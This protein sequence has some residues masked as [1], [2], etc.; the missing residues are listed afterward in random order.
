MSHDPNQDPHA[1]DSPNPSTTEPGTTESSTPAAQQSS[2]AESA[3]PQADA[4]QAE[5]SPTESP[6]DTAKQSRLIGSQR[7]QSVPQERPK[8]APVRPQKPE[9]A[10]SES[11]DEAEQAM[12]DSN[13]AEAEAAKSIN[14]PALTASNPDEHR[15][16]VGRDGKVEV[17]NI[18]ERMEDIEAELEAA[19]GGM[20]LDDVVSA[21]NVA[22]GA[23]RL[24]ADT[25]VNATIIRIH[26]EDV[27]FDLPGRNQGMAS[28][29]NFVALPNVG[30]KMEVVVRK[31]DPGE[32]L[33]DLGIPGASVS[34]SDWDD[35]EEG[36]VVDAVIDGVN[37]GGLEC[38]V[39]TARGFIPASQVATYHVEKLDEFLG[40]KMQCLVTEAKPEKR[41]L[42]LSARAVMEKTKEDNRKNLMGTLAVG[43]ILDGTVTRIQDFGAF[44]DVG[45]VDGLVHVS[46]IGWQRV[47]HPSDALSEGQAVRVKV[48]KI[49]PET[50]KIGLSIR[51]TLENPW[52][53][54]IGEYPVGSVAHGTITKIMEFG[55]FV[56]LTPGV[57]GLVHISEVSHQRV[58]RVESVA[59]VGQEVD[60]KVLSIDQAKRR[61][62][63]SMKALMSAPADGK[64]GKKQ[65]EEEDIDRELKVKK[66]PGQSLKG[67][68]TNDQ[69]EGAK[70]GLKW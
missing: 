22:Q 41:N 23:Q 26:R 69:S 5:S 4:P 21:E 14:D 28:I 45:G 48:T 12:A 7:E 32:G 46:Q 13:T 39:G 55:A 17:P 42:V 29:R 8:Q 58:S 64:G 57:E 65:A 49:D 9:S 54:L 47:Q 62:S 25:R 1:H 66:Q 6:E 35:I 60:V 10:K 63:L 36:M 43:Q 34:V 3:P 59:K 27:F 24:E 31:F 30:D 19:L 44:V 67:G 52:Q 61:I 37:K 70:F 18:R 15:L 33:Y 50:H 2:P 51:D 20:S 53:K 38:A 56:E 16:F 68:I 40:K 11:A